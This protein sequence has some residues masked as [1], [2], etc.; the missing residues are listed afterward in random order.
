VKDVDIDGGMVAFFQSPCEG[1]G[2]LEGNSLTEG[3]IRYGKNSD[4]S[5]LGS[6]KLTEIR[7]AS[8]IWLMGDVGAPTCGVRND[9]LP[10]GGY[11]TEITT[12]QPDPTRGWALPPYKQPAARHNGRAVFSFADGHVEGWMWIDLRQN[13]GDVFAVNSL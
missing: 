2:P 6:R 1:Y 9:E 8:Q 12:K 11:W 7:R 4:G 3:V 10:P 13:K 5:S